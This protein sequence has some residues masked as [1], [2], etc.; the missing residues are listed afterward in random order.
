MDFQRIDISMQ[1]KLISRLKNLGGMDI[2]ERRLPQDGHFKARVGDEEV[3]FRLSTLPTLYG[4]KAVVRLL[5][6]KQSRLGKNELGFFPEDLK[7][8]DVLFN[9]PF[10]AVFVTGP[11]GS[12]KSTTLSCFLEGLNTE[13]V[14]IVTVEDPVENPIPGVNHIIM[15][16]AAGF[17]FENALRSILRQ[18][19]D[20]IMIGEIRDKQT[21][22]IA[23]QAA[24]TGHLV[25]S[26]LHTNDA[27]GVLERLLD[28]GVEPYL[29]AAALAGVIAQRL[30]RHIC[31]DCKVQK[32]L[33]M[34]EALLLELP[35][36]APSFTG[37][38]CSRCGNTGYRGRF[39]VYEYIILD[40]AL[41]RHMIQEPE[42][43]AA[44]L[45][46]NRNGLKDNCLRNI[47]EGNT[48][49]REVIRA[50]NYD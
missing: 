38:G 18:D 39:A 15:E 33:S 48:T 36:D 40:D 14:N 12:G 43:F 27:A 4:E 42:S 7:K 19:P 41:K 35:P 26:T 45:R 50:L 13:D 20:I 29:V 24:V 9:R 34:E 21:A 30:V 31:P 47:T 46:R 49:A 10:G 23:I 17:N 1:P 25:L 3:D 2:S 32:P 8:L 44:E 37:A 11:T 6:G 22:R 5:Y 28:M 16:P